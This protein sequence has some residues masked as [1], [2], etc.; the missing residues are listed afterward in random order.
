MNGG[1]EGSREEGEGWGI[2]GE[3]R[4]KTEG[5]RVETLRVGMVEFGSAPSLTFFF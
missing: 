4:R 2:E 3:K 1:R 5:N